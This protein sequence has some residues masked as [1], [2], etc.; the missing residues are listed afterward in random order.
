MTVYAV[1][2]IQ[3]CLNPLQKLLDKVSFEPG[4]D[5]LWAAGDI[6]NRGPQSLDTMLN[7]T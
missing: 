1:G 6:V 3:G 4:K 7:V 2:D 5:Q